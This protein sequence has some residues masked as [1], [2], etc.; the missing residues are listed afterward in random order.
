MAI[1][2][3]KKASKIAE[4]TTTEILRQ[5]RIDEFGFNVVGGTSIDSLDHVSYQQMNRDANFMWLKNPLANNII[6]MF[7]DF[8]VGEKITFSATSEKV[9]EL[10]DEYWVINEWQKRGLDRFR[11]LSLHGELL[12]QPMVR[13]LT[14]MVKLTSIYPERISKIWRDEKDWERIAAVALDTKTEDQ[15]DIIKW[16]DMTKTYEGEFFLYQVNKPTFKSRGLSDVYSTRDWLRLY[17]KS[18]YATMERAGLLLS[19]VWDIEMEGA[20]R[21]QLKEKMKQIIMNPPKPGGFRVHNEKEK[22]TEKTPDLGG[23]QHEDLFRL[24]KS[25]IIGGSRQP[26]HFFGMGGDVNVSTAREMKV[27]FFK[28]V[29]RRQQLIDIILT[30]QFN[31][32]IWQAKQKGTISQDEDSSFIINIPEPNQ[33]AATELSETILKFSQALPLFEAN[34]YINKETANSVVAML[35]NQLGVRV[36]ED[37]ENQESIYDKLAKIGKMKKKPETSAKQ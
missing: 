8:L 21:Q 18:L 32:Q 13:P 20:N 16:N 30:E 25:Q 7:V 29:K 1:T 34:G 9:K 23:R 33:N 36:T 19:F 27:P 22:W 26:E 10:L 37:V 2:N 5:E 3:A 15:R 14:G 4:S 12:L 24:F 31:Y 28:K 6:E 17:D 35:F 11:D